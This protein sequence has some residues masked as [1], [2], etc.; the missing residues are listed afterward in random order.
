[1]LGTI[2]NGLMTEIERNP[3]LMRQAGAAVAVV[4]AAG[5]AMPVMASRGVEQR[6]EWTETA[7]AYHVQRSP[8]ALA[9]AGPA[10]RMGLQIQ[11]ASFANLRGRASAP[12]ALDAFDRQAMTVTASLQ[13]GVGELATMPE[14]LPNQVDRKAVRAND[15][16]CLA[17]AVYYEARSESY[18]GQLA[19]AE[20]VLNR[21]SSR[22]WPNTVCGVVY[23]GSHLN[24]G[25]Q[26]TFT[27]DGSQSKSPRG[28]AWRK[29]NAIAAQVLMGMTRPQTYGATHYHTHAVNPRWN[30]FLVETVT[31]G[32]HVFY[33]LPNRTERAELYEAAA[34]RGIYPGRARSTRNA[35]AATDA[36]TIDPSLN[37][38]SATTLD[39]QMDVAPPADAVIA[40][41]PA[42][43][44]P[45]DAP[46]ATSAGGEAETGA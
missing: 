24:T 26:F 43:E 40:P 3:R 27:C 37:A 29:A 44:A 18:N 39:P 31:I 9:E 25:C 6:A 45:S 46:I 7:G 30:N 34:R 28:S 21:V 2:R 15:L 20:V 19:V 4:A 41:A 10:A 22:H 13:E 35:E 32:D 8:Q 12:M 38:D 33:R 1:M 17:E 14:D 42:P 23:Q 16:R 5:I 11:K 36:G